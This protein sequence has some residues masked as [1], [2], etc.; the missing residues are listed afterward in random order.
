MKIKMTIELEMDRSK[1]NATDLE[2]EASLREMSEEMT[3]AFQDAVFKNVKCTV[4]RID[5]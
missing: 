3:E 4:E 5:S 2:I 1:S